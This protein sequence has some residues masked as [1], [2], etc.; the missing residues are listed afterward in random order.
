[1][2]A[3]FI[4]TAAAMALTLAGCDRGG[5]GDA[6]SGGGGGA[7]QVVRFSVLPTENAANLRT[8]WAPFIEDM[9]RQT[10]L[11]IE[12][13]FASNYTALVTAMAS[14]QVDAGWFSNASGLEAVRRGGGEVFA[15]SSDP[16]GVDGYNSVL[17]VNTTSPLT[18]EDV[19]R[20]DRRLDFG[21]GDA[22]ST[23]GTLAPVTYLFA[24]RNID[25]QRCFATVRTANHEANL[26]SV[27]NGLLDV[28]TNNSTNLKRLTAARPEVG[29]RVKVIWTSPLIPEDPIV[30]RKDLDPA[31][32]EKLRQFFLTY[33]TG[34]GAEAQRQRD[35]LRTLDFGTFRPADDSHL[36]PVREME[37]TERLL[38]ARNGRDAAATA[39]AERAL[40]DVQAEREEA[41]ARAGL[42]P[43][44]TIGPAPVAPVPAPPRSAA[45]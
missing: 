37:A 17:I 8:L 27:A 11:Q 12:P 24:P 2:K 35:V 22:R 40:A 4:W 3:R 29:A 23:S 7:P 20:C 32:K 15:R 44:S 25:P 13:V 41:D 5:Q 9:S 1:M 18:L 6:G 42:P 43:A 38:A 45:P 30:R 33:G 21:L 14:D 39:E 10:G 26:L 34:E 31:V 28:A 19:T 36:L 16:S